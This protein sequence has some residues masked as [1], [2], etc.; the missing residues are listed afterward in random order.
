MTVARVTSARGAGSGSGAA[1][2]GAAPAQAAALRRRRACASTSDV[3]GLGGVAAQDVAAVGRA[4]RPGQ[5]ELGEA[6]AGW[7]HVAVVGGSSPAR[8]AWTLIAYFDGSQ[9]TVG[10]SIW[11]RRSISLVHWPA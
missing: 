4:E 9:R 5:L 11:P 8:R 3:L 1:G 7:R 2:R 10:L 6:E